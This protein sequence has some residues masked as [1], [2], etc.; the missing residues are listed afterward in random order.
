MSTTLGSGAQSVLTVARPPAG[1]PWLPRLLPPHRRP[2]SA[3]TW[4]QQLALVAV[5]L[6]WALALLRLLVDPTPRVPLLVNW[7]GSLPY[8]LAWLDRS[9]RVLQRG[10][11][12]VYRF[13]GTAI[14]HYPGLR[15]QPFFKR[16]AGLPGDRVTVQGRTVAVNGVDVGTAK[17]R[18]WDRRPLQPIAPGVVPPGHFY[19][20]GSTADS[21]DSRYRSSGLVRVD[22]VLGV[23]RPIF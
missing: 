12:V 16:I 15:R 23:A 17:D 5:L 11:L 19:A 1:R 9:P 18:A 22:Q 4:P 20:Q 7:T 14:A 8:T 3:W 6:V 2:R 13:D 10:D 21:F